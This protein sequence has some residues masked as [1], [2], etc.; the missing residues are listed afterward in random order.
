MGFARSVLLAFV[1]F[2]PAVFVLSVLLDGLAFYVALAI[3]AM[4]LPLVLQWLERR[5]V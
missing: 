4:A 3:A 1:L 5:R 2:F